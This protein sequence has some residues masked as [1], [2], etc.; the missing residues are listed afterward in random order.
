[1]YLVQTMEWH[2]ERSMARLSFTML[3]LLV[4]GGVAL[5]LGTVGL[6]GVLSHLVGQRSRE[7]GIR[8]AIGARPEDVRRMTLVEGGRLILLGLVLGSAASVALTRRLT[9]LL[10][11]TTPFDP[12][13]FIATAIALLMTGLLASWLPA[14]RASAV[15]PMRTI[16]GDA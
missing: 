13:T 3:V 16:R 5:L 9:S 10:Y 12:M 6:Y 11:E 15:D 4:A 2:A 1:M 7:I 14:R 8:M